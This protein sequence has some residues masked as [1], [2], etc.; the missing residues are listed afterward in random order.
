MSGVCKEPTGK[1]VVSRL[2]GRVYGE[3]LREARALADPF[4]EA[5]FL[6]REAPGEPQGALKFRTRFHACFWLLQPVV[7]LCLPAKH[8][9]Y[10]HSGHGTGRSHA[11]ED[12][13]RYHSAVVKR[14][15]A[16]CVLYFVRL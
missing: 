11:A 3:L 6:A 5:G 8:S 10:L 4:T 12:W 7:S 13:I 1:A 9:H 16:I 2:N 14:R 15:A